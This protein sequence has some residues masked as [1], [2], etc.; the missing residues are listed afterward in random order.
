VIPLVGGTVTGAATRFG[1]WF[2]FALT[3][4]ML[5]AMISYVAYG[6][7][8]RWGHGCKRYGPLIFVCVAFPLIIAEPLR[9][10]L[11][12]EGVWTDDSSKVYRPGCESGYIDCMSVTGWLI[13]IGAT[14]IGF[15]LLFIGSLWNANIC[16]T[17]AKIRDQWRELR[18]EQAADK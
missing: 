16:K 13:T 8:K 9:H 18:K 5:I 4:A 12:D 15:V 2:G 14:Y 11:Q 3:A 1:H 17:C 6:L 7:K 10:I